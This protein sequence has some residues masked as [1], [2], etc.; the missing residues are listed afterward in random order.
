LSFL[1]THLLPAFLLAALSVAAYKPALH[2]VFVTDQIWYFAELNGQ[3]SLSAGLHFSDYAVARRY[4]KG[5][6][7]LFRPLSLV[8]LAVGN[9]L[10]SYHHVWWNA[11]TLGLHVLVALFLFRLLAAIQPSAFALAAAA[12]FAVMKPPLELVTWNHLG[13]Y[14]LACMFLAIALRSFVQQ[15]SEVGVYVAAFTAAALCHEAMVAVCFL[16]SSI[17][18]WSDWRQ[19]RLK[20]KRSFALFSPVFIF[21]ILYAGH[22]LRAGRLAYVDRPDVKSMFAPANILAIGPR[23]VEI[24]WSWIKELLAP[25]A[26]SFA[27]APFTRM[28]KMFVF[29]W[30][31]PMHVFNLLLCLGLVGLLAGSL[32]RRRLAR[33]LPLVVLL[34]AA[35]FAYIA[36]ICL[37]RGQTDVLA[38]TYYLY[39]FCFIAILL[40]YAVIDFNRLRGWMIP[41]AWTLVLTMIAVHAG[42]THATAWQIGFVNE[43]P[44]SYLSNLEQLVDAHKQEPD[45]KLMRGNAAADLDPE[46]PLIEGY[47]DD[48]RAGVR[49][50][51]LSE[52][53]FAPFY[54]DRK[55]ETR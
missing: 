27:A 26:L 31:S 49:V 23:S 22:V 52:I 9:S 30:R 15:P 29:S 47:P 6:D 36:I 18:V 2:R 5:D 41:I 16:S 40:A 35:C 25:S 54:D 20:P 24:V 43:R 28:S 45:F 7:A 11:A 48:P 39:F 42:E 17:L 13:G 4:W 53:L 55:P 44:S 8:W 51:R 37:G 33:A 1:K 19:G 14:L 50:R 46:V 38:T 34:C 12:L 32:S 21:S 3:T 10:F